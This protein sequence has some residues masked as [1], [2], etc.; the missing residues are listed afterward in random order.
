M[1]I[2]VVFQKSDGTIISGYVDP[3]SSS[4][5]LPPISALV[6]KGI[7]FTYRPNSTTAPITIQPDNLAV[8]VRVASPTDAFEMDQID[9]DTLRIK[10]DERN[11]QQPALPYKL[12]CQAWSPSESVE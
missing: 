5:A 3:T 8:V 2:V 12:E 11:P 4:D 9:F 6:P 10:P 7:P 1:R